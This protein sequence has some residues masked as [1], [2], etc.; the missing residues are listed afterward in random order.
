MPNNEQARHRRSTRHVLR[1][2]VQELCL[3]G[4]ACRALNSDHLPEQKPER[5]L[6]FPQCGNEGVCSSLVGKAAGG[7]NASLAERN[8]AACWC[9]YYE[10]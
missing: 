5:A 7:N 2:T 9:G 4:Q 10:G 6:F 1:K 8:R 3:S